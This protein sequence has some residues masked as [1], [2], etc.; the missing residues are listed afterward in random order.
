MASSPSC[1]TFSY[2]M[3]LTWMYINV[4][5]K[6]HQVDS[7]SGHKKAVE[8]GSHVAQASLEFIL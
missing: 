7:F 2:L 1:L 4:S 8:A 6:N 3:S 5:L